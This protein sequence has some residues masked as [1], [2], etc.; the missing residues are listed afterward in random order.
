[1]HILFCESWRPFYFLSKEVP[2]VARFFEFHRIQVSVMVASTSGMCF[3]YTLGV[4]DY[5]SRFGMVFY[6]TEILEGYNCVQYNTNI[7][8]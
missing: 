4:S 5:L 6:T 8:Y 2:L 1:M 3:V 7:C